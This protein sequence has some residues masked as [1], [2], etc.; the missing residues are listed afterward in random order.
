VYRTNLGSNLSAAANNFIEAGGLL[1]PC[2]SKSVRLGPYEVL[3]SFI[4]VKPPAAHEA[5]TAPF[6]LCYILQ[7]A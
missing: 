2:F 3:V 6:D 4:T 1:L 5:V 7:N